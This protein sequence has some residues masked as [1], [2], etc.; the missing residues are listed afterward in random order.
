MKGFGA[1]LAETA[2]SARDA[3]IKSTPVCP[4][5]GEI[6]EG[7][8]MGWFCY[9]NR[10]EHT[11]WLAERREAAFKYQGAGN[12]LFYSD[13]TL[14]ED[15]VKKHINWDPEMQGVILAV[16][17]IN[18]ETVFF[19]TVRGSYGRTNFRVDCPEN[20]EIPPS[21]GWQWAEWTGR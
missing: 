9:T 1:I 12:P 16:Q 4:L 14:S 3:R 19:M 13:L 18:G 21:D 11:R 6:M 20:G 15:A 10:E 17:Q 8:S 2:I 5:C 7:G